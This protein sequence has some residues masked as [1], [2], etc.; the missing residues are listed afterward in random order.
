MPA[1]S[2]QKQGPN[3]DKQHYMHNKTKAKSKD[4][5]LDTPSEIK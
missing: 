1:N 4:P 2:G 3:T 5:V